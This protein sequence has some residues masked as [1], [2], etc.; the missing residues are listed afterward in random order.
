[1]IFDLN[2]QLSLELYSNPNFITQSFLNQLINP[3]STIVFLDAKS[4]KLKTIAQL[5]DPANPNLTDYEKDVVEYVNLIHSYFHGEFSIKFIGVI[6]HIIEVYD[7]SP[8]DKD[9]KGTRMM[10]PLP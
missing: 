2:K 4:Y 1:D 8:G 7:N 5:I 9:A 10:P 3:I 6:Y